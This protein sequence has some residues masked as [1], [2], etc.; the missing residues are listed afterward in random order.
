ME[1]NCTIYKTADFIGKRWTIPILLELFK[2]DNQLK[3]YSHLKKNLLNITPK[4]LSA[5]LKELEKYKMIKKQIDTTN[6]P[7]K[8]EYFL[9]GSGK[10]FIKIIKSMKRW[11][12]KWNVRNK[13]CEEL[14]C[15]NCDID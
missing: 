6:V 15:K 1:K 8:C 10:D 2:G 11:A 5:R 7:I 12:L 3:R 9:T 13:V 4:M 14:N